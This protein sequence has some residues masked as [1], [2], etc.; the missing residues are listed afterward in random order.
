MFSNVVLFSSLG[1]QPWTYCRLYCIFSFLYF[2]LSYARND[3]VNSLSNCS[4]RNVQDQLVVTLGTSHVN[5]IIIIIIIY[6]SLT[7]FETM[8]PYSRTRWPPPSLRQHS[9]SNPNVEILHEDQDQDLI[10]QDL[11]IEMR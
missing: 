8:S 11:I 6:N 1:N 3:A 5:F 4:G 9:Q 7:Y 10:L 2:N